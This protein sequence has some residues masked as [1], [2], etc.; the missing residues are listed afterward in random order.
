MIQL[1]PDHIANQIAA[2]EVVQRPASALKE[3]L[4]NAIDAGATNITIVL[5]DAGRTLLQVVDNGCGMNST[6]ARMAF[7][8]HATSKIR[9]LDDLNAITTFGFRGE[10]L[11]SIAAV[12]EVTIKTRRQEDEIGTQVIISASEVTAQEPAACTAGTSIAVR[13]LF[14]NVPARR[15]FLKSDSVELKNLV[16]EMQRVALCHPEVA[17]TMQHNGANLYNLPAAN[18]RQRIVATMGK[19]INQHLI[20]VQVDTSVVRIKGFIG[21]PECVKRTASEQFFFVNN[22]FFRSAYFQKAIYNA[23]QHLLPEKACPVFFIYFELS[24]DKIDVNIHP[25]KIEVKFEEEHIIFQMLHAAV[26]EALGK[27][28][29][30]PSIDFNTEGAPDI[31]PMRKDAPAT[32]PFPRIDPAFNPFDDDKRTKP[33]S[34]GNSSGTPLKGWE[35]LYEGLSRSRQFETFPEEKTPEQLS[36]ERFTTERAIC[37]LKGKYILTPVKSGC[38]IIDRHRAQ[39]RILYERFLQNLTHPQQETQQEIFPQTVTLPPADYVLLESVL[40]DLTQIGYDIRP[41]GNNTVVVNGQPASFPAMDATQLIEELLYTLH[42][43]AADLKTQ[44]HEKL[45]LSLAKAAAG[46]SDEPLNMFEAQ[47]LVDNLFACKEPALSP[48]GKPTLQIITIE[49]IDKRFL[50]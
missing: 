38:M 22:R 2:G 27:F 26:R 45:A 7:E 32:L 4:E 8:R 6:D 48:E 1:L 37:Q 24:P 12:S 5:A 3:L 20:T 16:S 49:E 35:K 29:I 11:A 36:M 18:L 21:K 39:Q 42:E 13:N 44:R 14:F 46:T 43:N 28:A 10:A 33:A 15:K 19:E 50:K 9:R 31:P 40:D 34:A 23:Y 25:A 47:A 41:F 30:V 17:I